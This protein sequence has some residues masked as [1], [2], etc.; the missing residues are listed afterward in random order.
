MEHFTPAQDWQDDF[1]AAFINLAPADF[2]SAA[3]AE[4]PCPWQCPWMCWSDWRPAHADATK[5]A[6]AYYAE[7]EADL[8]AALAE[9]AALA[10]E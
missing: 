2:D 5:A 8:L 6:A 7:V 9:D 4:S 1:T 3:D 10:D